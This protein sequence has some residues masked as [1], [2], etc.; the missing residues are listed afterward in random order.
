MNLVRL[1]QKVKNIYYNLLALGSAKHKLDF[2]IVENSNNSQTKQ[3]KRGKL[4]GLSRKQKRRRLAVEE[5]SKEMVSQ[6]AA[7]RSSKTSLKPKKILKISESSA[8]ETPKKKST[9][10]QGSF[11]REVDNRKKPSVGNSSVKDKKSSPKFKSKNKSKSRHK[12]RR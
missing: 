3:L 7:A 4:D 10:K 1:N 5:D 8:K 11:D 9:T 2:G 12:K 6:K